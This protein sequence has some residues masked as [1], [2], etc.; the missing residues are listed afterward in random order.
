MNPALRLGMIT[1][2][3]AAYILAIFNGT[4]ACPA[5]YAR[6][7][8]FMQVVVGQFIGV[9]I[10]PDHVFSPASEGAQLGQAIFLIP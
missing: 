1:P 2:A 4:G 5:A 8:L 3:P 10:G 6:K 7:T 9:N